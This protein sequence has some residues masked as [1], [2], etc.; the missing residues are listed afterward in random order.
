MS[1]NSRKE[2][3]TLVPDAERLVGLAEDL[4]KYVEEVRHIVRQLIVPSRRDIGS[5]QS[6]HPAIRSCEEN[7]TPEQIYAERLRLIEAWKAL[8]SEQRKQLISSKSADT[9]GSSKLQAKP[10]N[11][12]LT[13]NGYAG[14]SLDFAQQFKFLQRECDRRRER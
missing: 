6:Q 11:S 12:P 8:E 5:C 4:A 3:I 13:G 7:A 2:L 14:E 9:P 10:M 1:T